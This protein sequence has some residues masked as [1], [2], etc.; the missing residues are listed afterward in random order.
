[1]KLGELVLRVMILAVATARLRRRMGRQLKRYLR[2]ERYYPIGRR[3]LAPRIP[4]S[5]Q[6][7][8]LWLKKSAEAVHPVA[9]APFL[10]QALPQALRFQYRADLGELGPIVPLQ[11]W[12]VPVR[13]C[14]NSRIP[15]RSVMT[16]PAAAAHFPLQ[17][18]R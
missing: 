12:E 3:G 2:L 10:H 9:A 14:L 6:E 13:C 8:V 15:V 11:I 5:N 4:R 18:E 1:M 17:M 16:S 7:G